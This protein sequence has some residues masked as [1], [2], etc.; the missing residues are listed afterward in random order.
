M[1]VATYYPATE[2]SMHDVSRYKT[3]EKRDKN[4]EGTR[5]FWIV[6]HSP[7]WFVPSRWLEFAHGPL[8]DQAWREIKEWAAKTPY[9]PLGPVLDRIGRD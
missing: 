3:F 2:R 4:M 1:R 6:C 8:R 9:K 7:R 5:G